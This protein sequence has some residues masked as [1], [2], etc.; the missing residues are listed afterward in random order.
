MSVS[1]PSRSRTA[2]LLCASLFST[3]RLHGQARESTLPDGE[4]KQLTTLVCS[5]CHGLRET[6][7]LRDGEPG[8][9]EVV[10]RMVLYGA[11]LSPP[12]AQLVTRYLA[13]QLGPF[14]TATPS[15]KTPSPGPHGKA[16][17]RVSLP[18]GPGKDLVGE[19]CALC[20]TLEK[21]VASPRTTADWNSV[22]QNMVQRGM[23]ATPSETQLIL[24]YLKANFS[25]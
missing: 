20:H 9:A 11:Q 19:R 8:W 12:E 16:T 3:L 7:I 1:I 6:A 18:D 25:K 5:Q 14:T 4:G 17:A 22:T 10:D 13:T 21:V 2:L 24:G 23:P 15:T